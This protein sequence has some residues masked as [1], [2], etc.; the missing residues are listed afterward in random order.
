VIEAGRAEVNVR[1][2]AGSS[3][4]SNDA[5]EVGVVDVVEVLIGI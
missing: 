2:G 5:D 3:S 1:S 4:V